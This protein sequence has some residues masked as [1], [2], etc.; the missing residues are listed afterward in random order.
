M[1]QRIEPASC[2]CAGSLYTSTLIHWIFY[3]NN[4]KDFEQLGNTERATSN[5]TQNNCNYKQDRNIFLFHMKKSGVG[6]P[7]LVSCLQDH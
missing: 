7:G 3:T 5:K 1:K 6:S 2:I 4:I